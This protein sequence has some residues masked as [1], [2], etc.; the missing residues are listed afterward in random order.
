MKKIF[1]LFAII[2]CTCN[3]RKN[4]VDNIDLSSSARSPII[5]LSE[6]AEDIDYIPLDTN[7]S[8]IAGRILDLRITDGSFYISTNNIVLRFDKFGK[9]I[10]KLNKFGR[11]P[12]EYDGLG[13]FDVSQDNKLLAIRARKSIVIY[14]II[15]AGFTFF[16]RLAF[17]EMPNVISFTGADN[18]LL[19]MFANTTGTNP[20][21]KILISL[22]GDTLS[23][24]INNL[25]Y[26]LK[27]GWVTL[28]LW[29]NLFYRYNNNLFIKDL[30][31][32][33]LFRLGEGNRLIPGVIFN[34]KDKGVTPNVRAEGRYFSD[35][36]LE[37]MQVQNIMESNSFLFF[38]LTYIHNG[39]LFAINKS[40]NVKYSIS[41]K[42]GLVD[43][44]AGG[45]NFKPRF[46]SNGIFYSWMDAFEIKQNFNK[47]RLSSTAIKDPLKKSIV[48]DLMDKLAEESNPVIIRVKMR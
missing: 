16:T 38:S 15:P 8:C 46:G 23:K 45:V 21:S 14:K 11:G 22:S 4:V 42:E 2:F 29:E 5:K 28:S 24:Y 37:F 9:Y 31:N 13:N 35:H 6:V 30:Q 17:S 39:G 47:I 32:D 18:N 48:T 1:I 34:S 27:D 20:Y 36:G 41:M 3:S 26:I 7:D 19:L 25:R 33:T 40:T 43:D 10:S 12:E 44:I